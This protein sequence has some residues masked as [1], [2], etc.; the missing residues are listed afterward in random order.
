VFR[1]IRSNRAWTRI[2]WS[3]DSEVELAVKLAFSVVQEIPG[4]SV[5]EGWCDIP[6]TA[7][8]LEDVDKLFLLT[9]VDAP[10]A[11]VVPANP[12]QPKRVL[13]DYQLHAVELMLEGELPG[14]I[15]AD[16]MG[17]GKSAEAAVAA[18]TLRKRRG[19]A[20]VVVGPLSA[21]ET[22]RNELLVLGF[23]EDGDELCVLESRSLDDD[24]WRSDASFYFVH[25]DVVRAWWSKLNQLP[26]IVVCIIDEAHRI[27]NSKTNR[28]KGTLM[29]A[30]AAH[31]RILLTGTPIDNR[32]SDL[33]NLLTIATGA[34]TW[35][36][37]IDFRRRY[38]GAVHDGYGWKDQEPTNTD[39]L[40]DRIAPMF[41]RRTA[42]DE[43]VEVELPD[44]TRTVQMTELGE[45]RREH[46][47]VLSTASMEEVV[48][49]IATG[50]VREV[51]P[52]LTRL[53]QVTS[54]A[55]LKGTIDFVSN[56][57]EEGQ[58]AVV[59]CWE[60]RTAEALY[61]GIYPAGYMVTGDTPQTRRDWAV[62]NF[63]QHGGVIVATYG[64]L[65]EAVTLHKGR[66]VVLHDLDWVM[67]NL[68]Q[69]EKRIHRVGQKNACQS[70]WMIANHSIDTI[71]LPIL[72]KKAKLA[73]EVLGM[74][75]GTDALRELDII[76]ERSMEDEIK[77]ALSLWEAM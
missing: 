53:R 14:F 40:Q 77:Q 56:A 19:G 43:R 1:A 64:T 59:F 15:L 70:V 42:K 2:L 45:Y 71:L 30:G 74:P 49:A 55:K 5:G 26:S 75:E 31:K 4:C 52:V 16:D 68:L 48:R 33:W 69:A 65:S 38:A 27:K 46:D 9:G 36:G 29:V 51:L 47:D 18:E 50:A 34:R 54:A 41:L 12:I 44:L 58:S 37:P 60:K 63:Q 10:V 22:W 67:S 24:S 17:L 57:L 66:L 25:Y 62:E 21:R 20:V 6:H 23:I 13:Y 76:E 72:L 8:G 61:N 11:T 28:A 35:G 3:K 7:L 73:E 32:P 39:E